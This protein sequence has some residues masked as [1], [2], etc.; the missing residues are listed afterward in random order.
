MIC[1]VSVSDIEECCQAVNGFSHQPYS[2]FHMAEDNYLIEPKD[3]VFSYM[4]KMICSVSVSG[5]EECCQAVNGCQ[6]VNGFS[7]QPSSSSREGEDSYLIEP[8]E[9]LFSYMNLM[10]RDDMY[11]FSLWH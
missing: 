11:C 8:E 2:S 9:L 3:L 5:F 4:K 6:T 10:M 1:S 7:S